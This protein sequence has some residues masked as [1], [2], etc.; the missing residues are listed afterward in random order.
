[1]YRLDYLFVLCLII[2]QPFLDDNWT[3]MNLYRIVRYRG[4]KPKRHGVKAVQKL[5][6]NAFGTLGDGFGVD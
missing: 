3:N 1:M 4:K 5:L 2:I 6:G